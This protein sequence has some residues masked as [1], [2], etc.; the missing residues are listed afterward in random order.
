[1]DEDDL[2]LWLVRIVVF[3]MLGGIGYVIVHFIVKYW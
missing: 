1:M 2:K 3:G